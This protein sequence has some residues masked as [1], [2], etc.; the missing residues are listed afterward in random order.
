[1]FQL[2][3]QRQSDKRG[4]LSMLYI[5]FNVKAHKSLADLGG[6]LGTPFPL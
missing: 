1:M 6:T 5:H 3:L 4:N 2:L